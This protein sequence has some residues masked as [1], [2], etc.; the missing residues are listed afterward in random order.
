MKV[1]TT[2]ESGGGNKRNSRQ[3]NALAMKLA[4]WRKWRAKVIENAM[5]RRWLKRLTD[6][7]IQKWMPQRDEM[8]RWTTAEH[9]SRSEVC[10]G[11]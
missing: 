6:E 1:Y 9:K 4:A 3:I 5:W 11:T 8:D 7:L 10:L 2:M